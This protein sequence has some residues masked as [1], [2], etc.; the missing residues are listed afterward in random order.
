MAPVL[1]ADPLRREALRVAWLM[2][3]AAIGLAAALL[4]T[5]LAQ[6]LGRGDDVAEVVATVV[7]LLPVALL[8][9]LP[10]VRDLEVTAARTLLG[11]RTELVLPE[12][13]TAAHRRRTCLTVVVHLVLGLAAGLLLVGGLP[14]LAA[15]V[16]AQV[17]GE[18]IDVA[19]WTIAPPPG[20]LGVLLTLVGT[21]L[22]LLLTSALGRLSARLVARLLGPSTED[23]L[24]VALSRLEAEAAHTRF[25]RELH[26]GIGHALTVI[27]LQAAA[28]RRVLE[29]DP[30]RT[31]AAL[32][33]IE[34]TARGALGELDDLLGSLRSGAVVRETAPGLDRVDALVDT[35]RH[36]G[37]TVES[38]VGALPWLPQLTSVTAYQVLAEGLTNAARHAGPGPVRLCLRTTPA[39]L[40][41][42]VVSPL[43]GS[44]A[45]GRAVPSVRGLG[46]TGL[47]ERVLL[48][49]GTATAG[50]D[51]SSWVLTA[52]LPR[53]A[54]RG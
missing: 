40:R 10:G 22:V 53:S 38:D 29:V 41:V 27:G 14:A 42:Q 5:G 35:F 51:G 28:G 19:G 36:G 1:L 30:R 20:M 13:P 16:L 4:L 24:E 48:L 3:G 52:E 9:L 44:S 43:P 2:V 25:A 47:R 50:P 18:P 39:A 23:R 33:T 37:M 31:A 32:G 26:D 11:V 12:R 45:E 54:A 46:L 7:L 8:G 21:A 15:T 34:E 49:G 6:V 17:R